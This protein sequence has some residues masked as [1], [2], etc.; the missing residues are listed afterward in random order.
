MGS[1][2]RVTFRSDAFRSDAIGQPTGPV[3]P[4]DKSRLQIVVAAG[5]EWGAVCKGRSSITRGGR[6]SIF[7]ACSRRVD[8]PG[9][10]TFARGGR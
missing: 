1:D 7:V 9:G 4:A 3:G 8:T 6:C 5:P 10:R 2:L